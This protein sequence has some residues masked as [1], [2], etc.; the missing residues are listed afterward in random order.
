MADDP[1]SERE[2]QE[3]IKVILPNK[4]GGPSGVPPGLLKAMPRNWIIFLVMSF[5]TILNTAITPARW[6]AIFRFRHVNY[7]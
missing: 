1:I 2:V 4:S 7:F 3:A 5:S 6:A